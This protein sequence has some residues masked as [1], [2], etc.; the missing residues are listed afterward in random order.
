MNIYTYLKK[1]HLKVARIFKKIVAAP[2]QKA[3]EILFLQ[4]KAL[5]ELHADPEH[6]TFYRALSKSAKGKEEAKHGDK[7]HKTIKKALA[8][9][10]RISSKEE[11]KWLVAFGELKHI[12][13]HHVDDEEKEMFKEG[14]KVIGTKK[15]LQLV[16][17]IEELKKKMKATKSFQ[18][19]FAAIK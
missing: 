6:N 2:D 16:K 10:S 9:I 15:S 8:K 14:K 4:V 18:Q 11:V 3:R 5:L 13:E 19:K 17:E 12:V 7:E 1:D